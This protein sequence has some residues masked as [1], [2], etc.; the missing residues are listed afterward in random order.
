[1]PAD[2]DFVEQDG[3]VWRY[4]ER[5]EDEQRTRALGL[6]AQGEARWRRR[7]GL[8]PVARSNP[9]VM[10]CGHLHRCVRVD[11]NG[12]EI[13]TACEWADQESARG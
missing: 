7:H 9:A 10:R 1:M 12:V 4:V 6:V 3:H 8:P 13:C 11:E 2:F 5:L